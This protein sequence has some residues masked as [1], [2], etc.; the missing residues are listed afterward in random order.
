MLL[1]FVLVSA[2]L[3]A[4]VDSINAPAVKAGDSW[5]YKTT[6]EKA[7]SGW[8]QTR[9]VFKV[10]RVSSSSIYFTVQPSGSTQPPKELFGGLDWSRARDIGGAETVV[11]K[12]L[13][14]PLV[15]G[16][17][18]KV[19]YTEDHP[20]NKLH[21]SEKWTEQFN[22]VGYESVDVPAGKFDA[23]KIEC[24]GHWTAELEPTKTVV[25]GAQ[26][27]A[28]GVSMSTQVA[29][30]GAGAKSGRVY[31]AFWYVPS[32]KRWVKSVEEYY[33]SGGVRNESYT[34]ELESFEVSP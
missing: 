32:V 33:S 4:P 13:S 7:T 5:T 27:N 10:S 23:L 11:N 3:A 16:K 17:T 29:N 20:S 30:T 31:K 21:K 22:V 6:T 8:T 9:D 24:E 26:A 2:A 1:Q 34:G 15:V 19:E 28:S 25:Q 12:P 18:W 14:F